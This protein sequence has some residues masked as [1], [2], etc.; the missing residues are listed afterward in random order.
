ME[1]SQDI[2][3]I[4]T[5]AV[6]YYR[7]YKHT[8]CMGLGIKGTDGG[9]EGGEGGR[10]GGRGGREGGREGGRDEGREGGRE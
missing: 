7:Q 5:S 1:S 10:E 6:I 3:Y 2:I 4:H 9:R 8:T